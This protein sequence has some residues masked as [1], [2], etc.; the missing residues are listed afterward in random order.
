MVTE[1]VCGGVSAQA[2]GKEEDVEKGCGVHLCCGGDVISRICA[3][4]LLAVARVLVR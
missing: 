2:Q 4:F 1:T 3:R